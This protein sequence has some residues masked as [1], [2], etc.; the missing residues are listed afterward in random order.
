M[1]NSLAGLVHISSAFSPTCQ[2]TIRLRPKMIHED[3]KVAATPKVN[4]GQ[5]IFQLPPTIRRGVRRIES[6][7]KKIINAEAAISFNNIYMYI[8]RKENEGYK[9]YFSQTVFP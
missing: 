4:F 3:R 9:V 7:S 1:E 8:S 6:L 5:V 2:F